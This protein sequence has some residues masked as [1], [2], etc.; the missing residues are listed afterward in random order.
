MLCSQLEEDLE[1]P[2]G[3]TGIVATVRILE[4]PGNQPDALPALDPDQNKRAAMAVETH[5]LVDWRVPGITEMNRHLVLSR[6]CPGSLRLIQ[7]REVDRRIRHNH[8]VA[9]G[10]K[11]LKRECGTKKLSDSRP[12]IL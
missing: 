7:A 6:L 10:I 9:T 1:E 2:S 4:R 11:T 5:L 12:D 8:L 3:G